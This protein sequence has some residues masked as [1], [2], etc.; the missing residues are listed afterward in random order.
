M[1]K[2]VVGIIGLGPAGSILAAHLANGGIN[3]VVEDISSKLLLRLKK[4][5]LTVSGITEL[6]VCFKGV[7]GSIAE[8][9]EFE[10]EIVFKSF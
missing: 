2:P 7:T 6:S 5:G 3:V 4:A 9:V 1:S 8:L 10:P